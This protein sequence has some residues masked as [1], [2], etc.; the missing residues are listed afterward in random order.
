MSAL[1][2]QEA[3][4]QLTSQPG[5]YNSV[6]SL[7]NLASQVNVNATGN[8]TILYSGQTASLDANGKPLLTPQQIFKAMELNGDSVRV[9]DSTD[10]AKFLKSDQFQV[11]LA[12]QYGLSSDD[13]RENP[14]DL[15]ATKQAA[16]KSMN[17][18]LYHATSGPWAEA[19]GRFVDATVGEVRTTKGVSIN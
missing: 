4:N 11:A 9:I 18:S 10:A 17:D 12:A 16:L 5:Q 3:L 19:S 6:Q 2:L 15:S 8:V 7:Y 1:T 14:A 13:L